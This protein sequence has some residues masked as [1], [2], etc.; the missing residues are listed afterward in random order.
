MPRE[1]KFIERER[2]SLTMFVEVKRREESSKI[3][4]SGLSSCRSNKEAWRMDSCDGH[5]AL[6]MLPTHQGVTQT[7]NMMSD[8]MYIIP[9]F[10]KT[11]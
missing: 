7:T 9:I 3:L 2:D 1:A 4:F 5:T 8:N 6:Q 10:L 11:A